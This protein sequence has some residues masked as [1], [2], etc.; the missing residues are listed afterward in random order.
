MNE[1]DVTATRS[2]V[3]LI[4]VIILITFCIFFYY[5]WNTTTTAYEKLITTQK[6]AQTTAGLNKPV[7]QV[8]D[9]EK[10]VYPK[11]DANIAQ[12]NKS[13][14][15]I[16]EAVKRLEKNQPTKEQIDD[17]FKSKSTVEISKFFTDNGYPNTIVGK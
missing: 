10:N 6:A 17:T 13:I 9:R 1:Q 16:D 15:T 11:I 4:G 3:E 7:D 5:K 12:I 14:K 8:T 2:K